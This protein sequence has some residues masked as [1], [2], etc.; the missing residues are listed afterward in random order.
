MYLRS[1]PMRKSRGW[2][3]PLACPIILK[4]ATELHTL[5]DAAHFILGALFPNLNLRALGTLSRR[6]HY[7][8]VRYRTNGGWGT[9]EV[10][11]WPQTTKP[12]I[13]PAHLVATKWN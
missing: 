1:N 10:F 2:S 4:D 13:R 12:I 7:L 3:A 11:A 9:T 8:F 5:G 6:V